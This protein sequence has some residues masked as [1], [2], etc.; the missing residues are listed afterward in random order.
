MLP[1]GTCQDGDTSIAATRRPR[2]CDERLLM[3][4]ALGLL[5]V[6]APFV[7]GTIA[8]LSVRH[9]FRI[10][11]MAIVATLLVWI[12]WAAARSRGLAV[13]VVVAFVVASS[14]AIG[15]A[16]VAGAHAAFGVIAVAVVVSAFATAGRALLADRSNG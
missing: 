7:A 13:A 11:W 5:C 2:E 10:A 4:H 3:R 14:G 12:A 9:D 16:V 15:V 6:A 1:S 8:A